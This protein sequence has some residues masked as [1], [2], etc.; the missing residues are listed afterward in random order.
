MTTD[1]ENNTKRYV[2]IKTYVIL[3]FAQ[4]GHN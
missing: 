3:D 4:L 2:K 1:F